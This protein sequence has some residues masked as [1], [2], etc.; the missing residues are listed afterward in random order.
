MSVSKRVGSLA[1][2]PALRGLPRGRGS[3][4]PSEVAR[5][6]RD[7]LLG[8]MTAA[9]AEL[10]YGN[11][12]I[13]DVVDRARVS[14]QS[15]YAQ[16]TDKEQCFLAAHERGMEL[17]LDL[18][19]DSAAR[20][21]AS[22]PREQLR[23]GIRTYLEMNAEQPEFAQ[24][25]L[26]ELQ[27]IGPRGLEARLAAHRRIALVLSAW[28]EGVRQA[29][30]NWPAVSQ[31]RYAAAVGAV[32]DLVFDLVAQGRSDEVPGLEEAA[33]AAVARLLEMRVTADE[34]R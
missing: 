23:A 2:V 5:A 33:F 34:R 21:L 30:P 8:A 27:A 16:F 6:Q 32:H 12:R 20:Q 14:R 17:V 22:K 11:V 4:P 7:R 18:V 13:S 10:G 29:N 31:E 25:M 28:H 26:I 3:L 9:V 19:Q 15:F 24:C 1:E